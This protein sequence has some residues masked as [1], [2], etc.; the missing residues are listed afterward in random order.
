M[1]K[2]LLSSL[3]GIFL[4]EG[5]S[6]AALILQTSALNVDT[7]SGVNFV[8]NQFNPALG[9]LTGV[10]VIVNS[11]FAAGSATVTNNS[12]T[13]NVTIRFI[14]SELDVF[15]APALGFNGYAGP[16]VS[17]NTSPTAKHPTNFVLS[18]LG[19][20]SFTVNAGQSLSGN[21][22]QEIAI[23]SGSLGSYLGGGT[24][25]FF[26]ISSINLTTI[27]SSYAVDST[28]YYAPTS[29]SLRYTYTASPSPV[30]EPGQVAASILLALGAGGFWVYRRWRAASWRLVSTS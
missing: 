30:P 4:Y 12:P 6:Q 2:H 21:A 1:K 19:Q 25:S 10:D 17:L 9:S 22:T 5:V 24:V 18:P 28:A 7:D 11:S 15:D 20:Q 23:S 16:T 29:L 27:G 8:F 26:A 3:M 14:Q 13:N